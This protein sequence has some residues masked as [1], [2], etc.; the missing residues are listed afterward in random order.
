MP[1]IIDRL[2]T[3]ARA[4]C[5]AR[6]HEMTPFRLAIGVSKREWYASECKVCNAWVFVINNPMPNETEISGPALAENCPGRS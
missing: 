4:T 2:K 6:G 1:R 5:K 3:E